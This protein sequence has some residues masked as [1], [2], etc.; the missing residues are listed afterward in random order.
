MVAWV[1]IYLDDLRL[2]DP[3]ECHVATVPYVAAS[4]HFGE[5]FIFC[6]FEFINWSGPQLVGLGANGHLLTR[7]IISRVVFEIRE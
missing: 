5:I 2:G 7:E 4:F 1:C 3:Y 6:W